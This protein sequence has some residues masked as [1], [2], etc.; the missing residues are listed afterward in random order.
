M[1]VDTGSLLETIESHDLMGAVDG[2]KPISLTGYQF[3]S[4]YNW[5]DDD[6]PVIYVPGRN[7]YISNSPLTC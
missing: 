4:S 7:C 5:V 1:L 6:A 2:D 3:L